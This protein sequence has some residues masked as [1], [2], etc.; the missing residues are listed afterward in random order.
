[1]RWNKRSIRVLRATNSYITVIEGSSICQSATRIVWLK[2][3][4]SPLWEASG[5]PTTTPWLKRLSVYTRR[6]SFVAV[7]PGTTW[8]RSSLPRLNG[9]IGLIIDG[10]WNRLAISHPSNLSR[11]IITSNKRQPGWLDSTNPDS[12]I[13]GAIHSQEWL[14]GSYRHSCGASPT[15]SR[16]CSVPAYRALPSEGSDPQR[17]PEIPPDPATDPSRLSMPSVSS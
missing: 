16:C 13:P 6:K 8:N 12:G 9:S 5:M 7:V 11:H 10:Y 14:R 4:S 3:V 17:E 15:E 2:R 1:M